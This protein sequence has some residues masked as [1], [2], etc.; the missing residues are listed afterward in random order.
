MEIE[1]APSTIQILSALTLK[2][3]SK[4]NSCSRRNS[5]QLQAIVAFPRAHLQG[6]TAFW[7]EIFQQYDVNKCVEIATTVLIQVVRQLKSV[8][9][10][11]RRSP[12]T[13]F[14]EISRTR[15][16]SVNF[17]H[18][19]RSRSSRRAAELT[20]IIAHTNMLHTSFDN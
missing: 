13:D 5:I 11:V 19:K 16:G 18:N 14:Y 10:T 8:W 3:Q 12:E 1:T 2:S 15:F 7:C 17:A 4:R 6:I 20:H 9:I